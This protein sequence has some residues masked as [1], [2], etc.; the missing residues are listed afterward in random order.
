MPATESKT[1]DHQGLL[2]KIAPLLLENGL[3]STTMD[4]VA[5]TLG[6]SK[7]T[8]YET[9]GSKSDM[10]LEVLDEIDNQNK[11]FAS[12]AFAEAENVMEALIVIFK[13]NR[14]LV[15][16]LNVDFY[17]DMDRLYKDKRKDFDRG[18][19]SFHERMLQMFKVGVEQ[20]MFRPDVDY[21]VQSRMMGLQ[22]E[23]LKRIEEL[24][25]PD[26]TIQRVFDSIIIGLLRS[27]AS[28]EGMRILDRLT[29]E[30]N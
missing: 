15:G 21:N 9:F 24:F 7:R 11:E 10:I 25:P 16:S 18:Q 3:K 22:M 28:P 30:L 2:R 23:G 27:I 6:I 14:D 29:Q 20:G 13:R 5:A 26:I 12:R 8:L 17:R 4:S 1:K 19:Q